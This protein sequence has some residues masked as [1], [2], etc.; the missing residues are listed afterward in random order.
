M[1]SSPPL[2]E[3]YRESPGTK[4]FNL[5]LLL[6]HPSSNPHSWRSFHHLTADSHRKHRRMF[7]LITS[8]VAGLLL[9]LFLVW[10]QF[11]RFIISLS[12][13][14]FW[15]S[16][17][18]WVAKFAFD[19]PT[20]STKYPQT[21]SLGHSHITSMRSHIHV[22][23]ILIG[24]RFPSIPPMPTNTRNTYPRNPDGQMYM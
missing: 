5:S 15:E 3:V 9:Y 18:K 8:W 14:Q 16:S 7:N 17:K 24:V 12:S 4:W 22:E 2:L 1:V 6:S 10:F 23:S 19:L 11:D 20:H 13:T 21:I